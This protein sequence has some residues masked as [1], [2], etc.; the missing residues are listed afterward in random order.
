[1]LAP[2]PAAVPDFDPSESTE[3]VREKVLAKLAEIRQR[4]STGRLQTDS[5]LFKLK[6]KL[7]EM[8]STDDVKR[9]NGYLRAAAA[10]APAELDEELPDAIPDPVAGEG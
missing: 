3:H 5:T 9:R 4:A 7:T 10:P 2:N 6:A 1:M 8:G